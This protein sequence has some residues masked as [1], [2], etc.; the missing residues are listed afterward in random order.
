MIRLLLGIALGAVLYAAYTGDVSAEGGAIPLDVAPGPINGQMHW[1]AQRTMKAAEYYTDPAYLGDVVECP[2]RSVTCNGVVA[3][4]EGLWFS[5]VGEVPVSIAVVVHPK[6]GDQ[7]WRK[8]LQWVRDAEQMFRNSGVQVRFLV[9]EI[10]TDDGLPDFKEQAY[11]Y[12]EDKYSAIAERTG[13]DLVA[14]LTP[15]YL[16]DRLCGIAQIGTTR[17]SVGLSVSGCDPITLAHELGHNFGLRHDIAQGGNPVLE[18][19]RGY[20]LDGK[21]ERGTIMSYSTTRYPLFSDKG[22]KVEGK[23]LGTDDANAASA[24]NGYK[25]NVALSW[26]RVYGPIGRD[27]VSVKTTEPPPEVV[28]CEE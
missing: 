24:L 21:C 25:T 14:V 19:G 2:E 11:Y 9:S 6:F 12:M 10:T 27:S 4:R 28:I 7:P 13:A 23:P 16:G 22:N 5:A 17:A 18:G 8:A 1:Y 20:C 26:E 3:N 15:H